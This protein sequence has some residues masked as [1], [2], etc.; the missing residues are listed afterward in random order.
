ML[1]QSLALIGLTLSLS[2]N[3]ATVFDSLTATW[4]DGSFI[5]YSFDDTEY[6]IDP[7]DPESALIDLVG[8]V[9]DV[10]V[11]SMGDH[12]AVYGWC[13]PSTVDVFEFR[14]L[15]D[16]DE[17]FSRIDFNTGWLYPTDTID[18]GQA[19][20]SWDKFLIPGDYHPNNHFIIESDSMLLGYLITGEAPSIAYEL[21]TSEVPT[22][23][24]AWLFGSALL[25]LAGIKR[26][27]A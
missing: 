19:L 18:Y 17:S 16:S 24:A 10:E 5:T 2:A 11:S 14:V 27:K 12:C 8:G 3:A 21:H 9:T 26:R 22:P 23:A 15:M 4:S 1:K 25:G 7:F 13:T 6:V 20:V